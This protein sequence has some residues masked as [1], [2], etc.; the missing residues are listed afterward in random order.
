MSSGNINKLSREAKAKQ[1][2]LLK[3]VKKVVDKD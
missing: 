3:K 2:K 1:L